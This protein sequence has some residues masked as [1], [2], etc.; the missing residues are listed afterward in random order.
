[1]DV[2]VGADDVKK[3]YAYKVQTTGSFAFTAD[4]AET[5]LS[6]LWQHPAKSPMVCTG[7]FVDRKGVYG[8]LAQQNTTGGADLYA[9]GKIVRY[10]YDG[11]T[12]L[13]PVALSGNNSGL[14]PV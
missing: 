10:T 3:L 11:S 4:K 13:T 1:M 5:E 8:L 2:K 9:L 14:N 12:Q 7:L 6:Q